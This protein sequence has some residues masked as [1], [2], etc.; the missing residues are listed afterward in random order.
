MCVELVSS[1][2]K[3]IIYAGNKL[4]SCCNCFSVAMV[5]HNN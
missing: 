3:K 2:N 5:K 4:I 1:A